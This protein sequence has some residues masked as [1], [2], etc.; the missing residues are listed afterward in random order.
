MNNKLYE[1]YASLKL[2]EKEIEEKLNELKP[3]ILQEFSD[4]GVD[5]LETDFG[6]FTVTNR[7]TWKYSPKVD[8]AEK[9]VDDLKEVEKA[10]GTAT[11]EEKPVLYFKVPT[12]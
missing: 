1:D 5:K 10:D 6:N 4:A 2:Q 9:V 7:K 8:E 11:A 12:V 3:L